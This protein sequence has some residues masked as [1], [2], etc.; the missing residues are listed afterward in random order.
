MRTDRCFVFASGNPGKLRELSALLEETGIRLRPQSEFDLPEV[1]ETGLTF[2]ENALLKAR[3]AAAGSRLPAIADDSGLEVDA[4]DG[5]PGIRSARFAGRQGDDQ[6]NNALLLERLAGLPAA[7]RTARFRCVIV[8]LAH[9]A[10]PA[11][12][13]CEGTWEGTIAEQPSGDRG[14][15]YDPVFVPRG[16]SVSAAELDPA[17]KNRLSHRGQALRKL[18][19]SLSA[20][21]A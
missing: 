13:I 4:L 14:F 8:S 12:L 7:R 9:P 5:E 11:P 16:M 10:D 19:E 17:V 6:A 3:A 1:D 2:V 20:V 18:I 15:G 21:P